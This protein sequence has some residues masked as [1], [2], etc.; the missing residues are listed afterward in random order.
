SQRTLPSPCRSLRK[1]SSPG[2]KLSAFCRGTMSITLASVIPVLL[3]PPARQGDQLPL[4][5][6]PARVGEEMADR[7]R[8][9]VVGDLRQIRSDVVIHRQLAVAREEHDGGRGELL[10]H[11]RDVEDRR[12]ADGRSGL[13]IRYAV[14]ALVDRAAVL[15]DA[16]AQPGSSVSR[17]AVKTRSA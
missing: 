17:N 6:Q 5:A 7:D 3:E 9:A 1:Y 16:E 15:A 4:I 8:R 14:T 12:R 2:L 10:R 11:G 13:E